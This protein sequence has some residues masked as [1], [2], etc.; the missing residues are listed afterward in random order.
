MFKSNS[1]L[2]LCF[3]AISINIVISVI[4]FFIFLFFSFLIYFLL[5]IGMNDE[6]FFF[7]LLFLCIFTVS[8]NLL[9]ST[10]SQISF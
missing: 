3:I 1:Y 10:R 9:Q 5:H 8:I 4:F 7:D 2:L 6:K